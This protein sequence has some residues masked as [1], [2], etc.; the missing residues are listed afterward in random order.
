MKKVFILFSLI[1]AID[2][3]GQQ[4]RDHKMPG[5]TNMGP[6]GIVDGVVLATEV[7]MRDAMQYEHVRLADYVWSKRVFSRIDAREKLNHELFY[8]FDKFDPEWLLKKDYES[9]VSDAHWIRHHER[10]SLWTVI[11]KHIFKGDL[12]IYYPYDPLTNKLDNPIRDGYQFK[13]PVVSGTGPIES[14]SD[15]EAF[16]LDKSF[17]GKVLRRLTNFKQG[18]EFALV[19]EFGEEFTMIK[20][21]A[22]FQNIMADPSSLELIDGAGD[23]ITLQD[24]IDYGEETQGKLKEQ[25]VEFEKAWNYS[26][27]GEGVETAPTIKILSSQAIVAYHIKED[28]FFDKERSMLD[29]RI[30]GIAPVAE[31]VV[32]PDAKNN[33][34]TKADES[35][36][37]YIDPETGQKFN[38]G[39]EISGTTFQTEMFWLYFPH[40]R[41]VMVNYYTYNDRSDAQWM[42]FD[43]LFWKRKF[44]AQIYRTSDKFDRNIED[45][46][47]GVD[48]LREA[49]KIKGE[50]RKWEHDVWNY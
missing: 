8:P 47:F 48:A 41:D 2:G 23:K 26:P 12:R 34:S 30:I 40:L 25:M 38:N 49:E 5:P 50:I 42:T 13:Y 24:F 46:R 4:N 45:Y 21:N 3:Y 17:Q 33:P 37:V 6:G 35:N 39:A 20:T 22:T 14:S 10:Y 36:I 7:P 18:L 19:N 44:N 32:R 43:D 15:G 28:W 11:L 1:L 9:T 31:Y 16:F 27:V 29:K